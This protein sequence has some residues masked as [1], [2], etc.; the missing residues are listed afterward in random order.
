MAE[1]K[2]VKLLG[3]DWKYFLILTAVV[4]GLMYTGYLPASLAGQLPLL[5]VLG[6][7]LRWIG[8]RIPIVKDYLGG[9]SCVVLF[10]CAAL[11]MFGIIPAETAELTK[12]F[13]NN[14]FINFALAALCC[15]SIFGMDRD[16]L[17]KSSLRY[18]PCILG[19]VICAL[20]LV[21]LVG[22][23]MGFG[24]GDA[25]LYIGLPIMGGGSSA[26]A[27]PMSQI[28]ADATGRDAGEI[29]AIMTP[30]VALGNAASIIM[31]GLLDKLGHAKP[32]MSGDG[33]ILRIEGEAY[34]ETKKKMDPISDLSKFACGIAVSGTFL[35]IG[36]MIQKVLVPSVHAYAWMII[37]MV[38][39]KILGIFPKEIEESCALWYQFFIKNFTNVLLAGLGIGILSLEAVVSAFNVTYIILVVVTIIGATIGAGLVGYLVGF[40]PIEAA[41]T[42]GLCMANMGGSGDIAT[43]GAAKRME[44]MP[45]AAVSSRIGGA[46]MLILASLLLNV[47]M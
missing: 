34:K 12:D 17:I 10:G 45:F 9:G 38:L 29:L 26:G 11:V 42:G 46:L 22:A 47:L 14:H 20:V 31:A 15:G 2:S 18:I 28:F 5:L 44:L 8:D 19:G 13:M 21:G 16:L 35:G 7:G 43:L 1:K 3:M 6:E 27:V 39:V 41:I 40:Y 4:L 32:A 25:I 36:T 37:L 30:A 33:N 23:V 24:L